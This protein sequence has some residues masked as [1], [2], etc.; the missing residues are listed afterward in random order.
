MKLT[1]RPLSLWVAYTLTN[2]NEVEKL[3]P[4]DLFLAPAG[5]LQ[6]DSNNLPSKKLLFNA[7]EVS[8]TFMNGH[9]L[10]VQTLAVNP[11]KGSFHLVVLD[12]YS[13]APSWDPKNGLVGPTA[14][15]ERK[16]LPST[17]GKLAFLENGREVFAVSGD[18]EESTY[19][20]SSFVVEANRECYFGDSEPGYKMSFDESNVMQPVRKMRLSSVMKNNLWKKWRSSKPSHVF[21]HTSAMEF[22]VKVPELWYDVFG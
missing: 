4:K 16:R 20:E 13:N 9:R 6:T 17:F 18:L 8:S 1:I 11:K 14:R 19:P 12:C 10:E 2:P 7:Y 3:L 21:V 15:I 5:L 22:D